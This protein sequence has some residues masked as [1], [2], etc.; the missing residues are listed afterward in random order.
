[1]KGLGARTDFR[2]LPNKTHFDLY[3]VGDDRHGPDAPDRLGNVRGR[4]AG[5][6]AAGFVPT[7]IARVEITPICGKLR[8]RSLGGV[9]P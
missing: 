4:A 9:S 8:R 2:Y 7:L 1:M 6:E 3:D 5:L